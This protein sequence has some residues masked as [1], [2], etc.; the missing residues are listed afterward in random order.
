MMDSGADAVVASYGKH[1]SFCKDV[2]DAEGQ[3]TS[4]NGTISPVV[5]VGRVDLN[6]F[7][8]GK[9]RRKVKGQRVLLVAGDWD[10]FLIGKPALRMMHLLPE[11]NME[12]G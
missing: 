9:L 2:K 6:V 8:N 1:G 11:Q 7:K 4:A 5:K 10:Y 12:L 3:V